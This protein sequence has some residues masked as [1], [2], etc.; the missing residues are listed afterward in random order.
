MTRFDSPPGASRSTEPPAQRS[1][2]KVL[3][4]VAALA[5]AGGCGDDAP[6]GVTTED[7]EGVWSGR[8]AN[9]TLLGRTI[10][11]DIDWRFTRDNFHIT[12]LAPPVGGAELM[13]GSWKF[14]DGKVVLELKTSFPIQDDIGARDTLFVSIFQNE[15]SIRT[16]AGSDILLRKTALSK[17][18][19]RERD[20]RLCRSTALRPPKPSA[21]TLPASRNDRRC[22]PAWSR[23]RRSKRA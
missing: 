18:S 3:L 1:C 16:L 15:I 9:V 13:G 22:C 7:L 19:Q 21:L 6:T 17:S 5:V 12:F 10:S 23:G 20:I 8:V 4:L 14:S 2:L 11:G